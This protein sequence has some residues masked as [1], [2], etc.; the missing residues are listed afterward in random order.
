MGRHWGTRKWK[1]IGRA[2]DFRS[3]EI[4]RI[5]R[6]GLRCNAHF[7]T[8]HSPGSK[9]RSSVT[10]ARTPPRSRRRT[11]TLPDSAPTPFSFRVRLKWSMNRLDGS[12]LCLCPEAT[13][14]QK[15]PSGMRGSNALLR[16]G[17]AEVV[18]HPICFTSRGK[19]REANGVLSASQR[20]RA[21]NESS[22]SPSRVRRR[23]RC[24]T[25]IVAISN[26]PAAEL[27]MTAARR[28]RNWASGRNG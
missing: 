14:G 1:Q 27:L 25:K 7:A 16:P 28:E 24:A 10:K 15:I 5:P 17:Q 20:Q 8:T 9:G 11:C 21:N 12:I 3:F 2:S 18:H 6:T 19:F 23:G 26:M 22:D 4:E 13:A